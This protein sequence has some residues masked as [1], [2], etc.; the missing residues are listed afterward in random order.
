MKSKPRPGEGART[1]RARA[2]GPVTIEM[3]AQAAGVSLST[4]SRILNGTAVVSELKRQAIDSRFYGAALRGIGDELDPA[5]YNSL[6][7]SGHWTGL[8]WVLRRPFRVR[9][10]AKCRVAVSAIGPS[11]ARE[12][13]V[14]TFATTSVA[15]SLRT[16]YMASTDKTQESPPRRAMARSSQWML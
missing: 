3:V 1:S 15:V 12:A 11:G 13:A 4:V 8:S 14:E 6:F 7:V 5:G 16:A 9:R 2:Q 10:S